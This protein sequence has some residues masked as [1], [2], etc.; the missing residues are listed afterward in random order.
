VKI[1][2]ATSSPSQ[3]E[4]RQFGPSP[5]GPFFAGAERDSKDGRLFSAMRSG[6][7]TTQLVDYLLDLQKLPMS[8]VLFRCPP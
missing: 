8:L 2:L 3:R 4:A 7:S 5:E 6:E 1:A